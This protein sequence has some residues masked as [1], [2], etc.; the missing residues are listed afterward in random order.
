MTAATSPQSLALEDANVI[1]KTPLS[2]RTIVILAAALDHVVRSGGIE[3]SLSAIPA[4]EE[5]TAVRNAKLGKQ[6]KRTS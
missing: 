4:L 3:A 5:L 1:Y 2:G 6:R